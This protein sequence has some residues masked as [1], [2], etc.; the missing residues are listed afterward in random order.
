MALKQ[1]PYDSLADYIGQEVGVSDWHD[2]TQEDVNTFAKVTR[3]EQWIH[4]DV[5]RCKTD[6]PFG[7]TVAHGFYTLSLAPYLLAQ[8]WEVTGTK[9]VV[10]YGCE[11]MRFPAPV[12]IPSRIRARATFQAIKEVPGC[13]Q[14][15]V[16]ISI[17]TEKGDKPVLAIESVMRYYG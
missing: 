1:I 17:E 5:E 13:K 6:S 10:N 11:K 3:D 14:L 8:I 16:A 12:P 15:T 9:M 2:V 7:C 4:I